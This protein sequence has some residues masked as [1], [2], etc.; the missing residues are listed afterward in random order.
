MINTLKTPKTLCRI[1]N[2]LIAC[3]ALALVG[4]VTIQPTYKEEVYFADYR[5]YS[6][7]GFTIAASSAG[8]TYTSIGDLEM[9]FST[10]VIEN[11]EKAPS[12]GTGTLGEY[13]AKRDTIYYPTF[14]EMTEKMVRKAQELGANA[15][16]N[17]SIRRHGERVYSDGMTQS[18]LPQYIVSGFAVKLKE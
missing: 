7:E 14:D 9:V 11:T 15:L 13:S 4:C 17:F 10:G 16:L 12:D 5:P 1:A 2:T 6:A 8:F 3:S 18:Y